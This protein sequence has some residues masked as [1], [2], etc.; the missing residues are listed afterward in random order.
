[1]GLAVDVGIILLYFAAISAIGLRM[2]RRE[3]TLRDF[4]LGGR[5]IP[6]WAVMASI[7]AAETSAATF[8]G[9]PTEGFKKQSLAYALLTFGV[10]LG[11]YVVARWFLKPF[12]TYRV[13]TVYDYL[14]IRFGPKTK[15]FVSGLF[16]VMRTLASGTRLFIP[17]IVMVLAWQVLQN[18]GQPVVVSQK[19]VDDVMPY[20]IAIVLL[21]I[22]TGIYTVKGGIKAVIWT[23]VVQ[24]SLMFG[25]ALLAMFTL[26]SHIGGL[27]EL[28]HL[29]PKMGT[30]QGYFVSGF[31]RASIQDW[32]V[33]QKMIPGGAEP[34]PMGPLG[35]LKEIITNDYTLVSAVIAATA[36]NIAAFGTDQD[37]VQRLL[38][39][40]TAAKARRSL[41]TAACM[42]IP[43]ASLFTFIGI[44][45]VAYY[46]QNPA[47]LPKSQ[48]DVFGSYILNVMPTGI[49]G[50]VLAGVFATAMGSLSAALNALA[51][52]ATND[53]YVPYMARRGA[54]EQTAILKAARVFSVI[55]ALLMVV[56]AGAFAYLKV[57][58]PDIGIIPVVL[59]IA[60]YILGPMLGV[61]LLG[62]FTKG[63]GND[64]GNIIALIVGLLA[65]S[66]LGDLPGKISPGWSLNL[67][68]QVSFTWF[69]FIGAVTV[70]AVG[71][72]FRTPGAV[73]TQAE[74]RAASAEGSD[75]L[76]PALRQ[77]NV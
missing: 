23:D 20:L 68:W 71:I 53:F 56:V 41:M 67:G 29:V 64:Q 46:K 31:D 32:Q 73:L 48:A 1:V 55:F 8:L 40:E 39:S 72:W 27:G 34:L 38:T 58:N 10:I 15:N 28:T 62:M 30:L 36:M 75:D 24:A 3:K 66:I 76:P 11:R 61:F 51:T 13:Y 26:I 50:L 12:Y 9:A 70:I 14:A 2:G 47:F 60:G 18:H 54:V 57:K 74:A 49:R 6:W 65:T 21:S 52:S 77:E 69:A 5:A 17:S 44:L 45:L 59:G 43:I 35:Y 63:R 22:L 7:I 19:P 25:A 16:L 42:D 37:M 4:A 33:A